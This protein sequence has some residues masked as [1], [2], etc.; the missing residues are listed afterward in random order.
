MNNCVIIII[1]MMELPCIFNGWM[2]QGDA[3]L[4]LGSIL[5]WQFFM[6]G[7]IGLINGLADERI[8]ERGTP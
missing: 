2:F 5:A 6:L 1:G 4:F 3:N 7:L 8:S